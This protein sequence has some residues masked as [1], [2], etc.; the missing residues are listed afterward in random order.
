[1]SQERRASIS[2]VT[3]VSDGAARLAVLLALAFATPA[4]SYPAFQMY[5]EKH[6]GRATNCSMCHLNDNGPTGDGPGQI[7]SL[8]KEELARLDLARAA[9]AP[10]QQ[11]NSPILNAFGN[12]IISTLGRAKFLQLM[13]DPGQL[14]PALGNKSDLDGDGIPDSVEYLEGTDPL[15]KYSGDPWRL[16]TINFARN[17]LDILLAVFAVAATSYG[18][19]HILH[20]LALSMPKHNAIDG[21]QE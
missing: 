2:P 13:A 5:V 18:L 7:G 4:N 6:S 19:S 17:W 10:G 15:N 12:H 9:M 20:A 3:A 16:F 11:V 8:T 1:M 21:E 14:A